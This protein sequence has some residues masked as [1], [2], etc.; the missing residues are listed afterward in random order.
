M[1]LTRKRKRKCSFETFEVDEASD[2]C[3]IIKLLAF[4]TLSVPED[5]SVYCS[6]RQIEIETGIPKR[7]VTKTLEYIKE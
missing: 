6:A 5:A 2:E 3:K 1:A 7:R 4:R